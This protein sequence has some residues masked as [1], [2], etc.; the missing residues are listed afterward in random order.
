MSNQINYF[1]CK[2]N[3]CWLKYCI[4]FDYYAYFLGTGRTDHGAL[5]ILGTAKAPK[6]ARLSQACISFARPKYGGTVYRT[7]CEAGLSLAGLTLGRFKY[8]YHERPNRR[9]NT[10]SVHNSDYPTNNKK[11]FTHSRQCKVDQIM[12]TQGASF[13]IVQR[14][15]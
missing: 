10:Y 4:Q 9:R 13:P 15:F 3:L 5:A 12:K 14:L 7:D 2:F 6:S 8:Y 11:G 1:Q